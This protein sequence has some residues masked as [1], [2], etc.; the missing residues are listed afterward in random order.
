M[1]TSSNTNK[2]LALINSDMEDTDEQSQF[3]TFT[4]REE[5]F[6][7]GILHILVLARALFHYCLP[8]LCIPDH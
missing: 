4:L 5:T 2:S 3:L 7:I 6:A 1:S 8:D